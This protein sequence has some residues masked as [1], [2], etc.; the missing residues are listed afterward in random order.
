MNKKRGIPAELSDIENMLYIYSQNV[1]GK[2]LEEIREKY[3][4]K[5]D[6]TA[7]SE[8]VQHDIEEGENGEG[9][10]QQDQEDEVMNDF[11]IL[12]HA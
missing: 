5:E 9:K 2:V 7:E 11:P 8:D 3:H 10:S 12:M 1:T 4:K 6:S